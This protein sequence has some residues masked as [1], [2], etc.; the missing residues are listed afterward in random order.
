[1]VSRFI[2]LYLIILS[3]LW[4]LLVQR[5][6]NCPSVIQTSLINVDQTIWVRLS[7]SFSAVWFYTLDLNS[8]VFV[9]MLMRGYISP[10]K[11]C[12]TMACFYAISISLISIG[13]HPYAH[14]VLC[15]LPCVDYFYVPWLII[16]SR[17]WWSSVEIMFIVFGRDISPVLQTREIFLHKTNPDDLQRWSPQS[18]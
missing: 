9:H 2:Q 5:A 11:L 6:L 13:H 15:R 3:P 8:L 7:S 10:R 12:C 1:M 18:A 16:T 4:L 17:S 14:Y